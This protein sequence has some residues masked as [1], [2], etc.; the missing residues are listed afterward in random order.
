ML[1]TTADCRLHP[2]AHR[3]PPYH[4][5][6]VISVN[7]PQLVLAILVK[8]RSFVCNLHAP[9]RMTAGKDWGI[10]FKGN[11][12]DERF[13]AAAAFS[14]QFDSEPMNMTIL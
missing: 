6:T 4:P 11:F 9:V 14:S 3:P 13:S 12:L 5:F 8:L 2:E 10:Q 7:P 1:T